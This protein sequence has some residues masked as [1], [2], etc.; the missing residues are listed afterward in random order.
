MPRVKKFVITWSAIV[1]VSAVLAALFFWWIF[2]PVNTGDIAV[3][4]ITVP[5]GSSVTGIVNQLQ[6]EGLVRSSLALR[7]ML[8]GKDA[9]A[10]IQSGSYEL[11]P[12]MT[13]GEIADQLLTG[14]KDNWVTLLEGW[15]AEEV[16]D[17]L[18]KEFGIRYFNPTD[19]LEL[20]K[21][22]EGKLFPD[23]YLFPKQAS[24]SLVLSTLLNVF[25]KKYQQAVTEVGKPQ[26]EK[27]EVI[28]L[29]SLLEREAKS[30]KDKKI[31][32][33]ILM[34]RLNAGIAL[35]VDATLQYVKGYDSVTK[36]WWPVPR[37]AD[38]SLK[39]PFNTYMH[40]GLPPAPICN[41]GLN[42]LKA[43]IAPTESDYLYYLT[44]QEGV[45]HYAR[46]LVEHNANVDRYL[47]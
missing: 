30:L 8:R 43:A 17:E 6:K 38:K 14:A 23:T 4:H 2:S 1:V 3:R 28:V 20:A 40:R 18:A 31:V 7:L 12:S 19:F 33:G 45:M 42:A 26:L 5:K 37:G 10:T 16:A 35:Q 21:P 47:R 41:P 22:S 46:T 25:E 13:V 36:T 29:A 11:S 15:R 24:A 27:D 44:D 34:N 9:S 32:A 39:S